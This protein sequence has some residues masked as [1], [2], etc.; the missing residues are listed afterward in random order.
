MDRGPPVWYIDTCGPAMN[1][2]NEDECIVWQ[3]QASVEVLH[4]IAESSILL[5]DQQPG[6]S[7][8]IEY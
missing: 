4:I 8:V 7:T 3:I 1:L 5:H 6:C 2:F